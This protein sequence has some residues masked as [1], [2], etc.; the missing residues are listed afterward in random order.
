[1]ASL[2]PHRNAN[3]R[4]K[5][6]FVVLTTTS[7]LLGEGECYLCALPVFLL[8]FLFLID[9]YQLFAYKIN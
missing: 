3:M 6:H 4:G 1:M 7:Q 2:D 8:C 9:R 5:G